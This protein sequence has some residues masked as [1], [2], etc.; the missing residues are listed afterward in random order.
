VFRQALGLGRSSGRGTMGDYV[1]LTGLWATDDPYVL[2]IVAITY[3]DQTNE[4]KPCCGVVWQN[5]QK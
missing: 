5:E 4:A 1:R 2:Y 3:V